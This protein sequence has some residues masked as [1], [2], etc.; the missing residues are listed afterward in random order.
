[1]D[2]KLDVDN[3]LLCIHYVLFFFFVLIFVVCGTIRKSHHPI[4]LYLK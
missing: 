1:M 2:T 4:Y 3:A